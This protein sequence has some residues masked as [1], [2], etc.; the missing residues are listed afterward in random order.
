MALLLFHQTQVQFLARLR[1]DFRNA[2]G[3]YAVHLGERILT[4]IS[5]NDLTDAQ[6]RAAWGGLGVAAWTAAKN[7]MS[8]R[9]TARNTIRGA[10][11]E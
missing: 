4:F 10:T 5:A 6:C 7:R 11:G 3:A 1:E 8:A 2:K 9:I